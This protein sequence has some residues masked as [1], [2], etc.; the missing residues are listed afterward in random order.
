[1]MNNGSSSS[2]LTLLIAVGGALACI[3]FQGSPSANPDSRS[4]RRDAPAKFGTRATQEGQPLIVDKT[5]TAT[6]VGTVFS[7]YEA[8]R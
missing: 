7:V 4:I 1:M 8:A 6:A 3:Q 2:A 5:W